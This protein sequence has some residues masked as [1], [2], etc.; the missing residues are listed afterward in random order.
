MGRFAGTR[1]R[2]EQ[3]ENYT[4]DENKV[5]RVVQKLL[6]FFKKNWNKIA[7]LDQKTCE[8]ETMIGKL[9]KNFITSSL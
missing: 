2:E 4:G 3:D 7:N 9:G 6:V 5:Q 8:K 1:K